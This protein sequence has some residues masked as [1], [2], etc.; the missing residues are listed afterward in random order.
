MGKYQQSTNSVTEGGLEMRKKFSIIFCL[1]LG[2]CCFGMESF[3]ADEQVE[4]WIH[5]W[6]EDGKKV[7]G[8]EQL[9]FDVYDLTT[10]RSEHGEDEKKDKEYLLN[11]YST[12]E[13]MKSFVEEQQLKKWNESALGVD[14]SGNVSFYVPRYSDG[15]D[16][17]YLILASGETGNYQ[18]LPIVLYL[19]QKHPKTEE[20]AQRLLIYGKYQDISEPPISS[21]APP[22]E[23]VPP[24]P[25]P[26]RP[27]KNLPSTNDL[28][29]NFTILGSV[30]VITGILGLKKIQKKK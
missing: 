8:T 29:R 6:K 24:S 2:I 30:L 7:E 18:M 15:K 4:L 10:W 11:T 19:P 21:S 28:I 5:T 3:A 1:L 12:K 27:I 14:G 26:D 16:A 22:T 25:V 17:A 13:S 20:E 9:K 23:S